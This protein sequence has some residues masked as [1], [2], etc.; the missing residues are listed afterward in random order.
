MVADPEWRRKIWVGG[1]VLMLPFIGWP[2]ILGYRTETIGCLLRGQSPL[3]PDWR[4][5]LWRYFAKGMK[6]VL[7]INTWYLPA[8]FW[9]V[10]RVLQSPHASEFPWLVFCVFFA[11]IPILSTLAVPALVLFARFG[12]AEPA[13]SLPESLAIGFIFSLATFLIPA[14]FLNVSRTGRFLS[15]FNLAWILCLLYRNPRA[16]LEAWVGSGI[17]SLL[18]HFCLPLAPWGI[19]WAYLGIVYFFNELPALK[20]ETNDT[21]YLQESWFTDFR[22]RY[23]N[24]YESSGKR[25]VRHYV[26]REPV[27]GAHRALPANRFTALQF[28]P[29]S[30]PLR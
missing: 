4:W 24:Q 18:G 14:G 29:I 8:Y 20:P 9:V 26:P 22:T 12:L 7:V 10:C 16:Y 25:L 15:A 30:V 6:A 28:G 21:D 5:G 13:L 3:L 1:W 23:W 17:I 11:A 2:A 27:E 19:T